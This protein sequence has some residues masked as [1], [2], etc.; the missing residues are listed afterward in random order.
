[1][2]KCNICGKVGLKGSKGVHMH[3]VKAGELGNNNNNVQKTYA[4]DLATFSSQTSQRR[5]SKT[6]DET[7]ERFYQ[8]VEWAR[9]AVDV[10]QRAAVSS[11]YRI[12]RKKDKRVKKRTLEAIEEFFEAP[13]S[14]DHIEDMIGDAICDLETFGNAYWEVRVDNSAMPKFLNDLRKGRFDSSKD[15]YPFELYVINAKT[16]TI[17]FDSRGITGYVQ[18]V[19]GNKV[20]FTPS[21]IIHFKLSGA[22]MDVY[23]L[24]PM[25]SLQNAMASDILGS[26]Y[27]SKFFENDA[28]PRLHIDL[29]NV[30]PEQVQA[31][32]TRVEAKLKGEPHKNLVTS[33]NVTVNPIGVNNKDMEFQTYLDKLMQR[34]FAVYGVPAAIFGIGDIREME[35]Q[36]TLFTSL[37]VKP[38]Q[39]L[40]ARRITRKVLRVL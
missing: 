39:N 12:A 19:S 36:V 8:L 37:T 31:F 34:I 1:M 23:G 25:K 18:N 22:G 32:A 15:T 29:G 27:N 20:S 21:Q 5:P 6:T 16:V 3:Q 33:G 38:I 10:I 35:E 28:T 4:P 14:E 40:V 24:S 9:A 11:G 26:N 13:N 30:T 2:A 7:Y 17:E